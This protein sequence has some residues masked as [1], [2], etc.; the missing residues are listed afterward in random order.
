MVK[1]IA[2]SGL[3]P[4]VDWAYGPLGDCRGYTPKKKTAKDFKRRERNKVARKTR[5]NKKR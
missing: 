2:F 3:S 1:S 4:S 5:K